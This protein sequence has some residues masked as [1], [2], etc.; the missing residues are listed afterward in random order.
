MPD[1]TSEVEKMIAKVE[2][3][4]ELSRPKAIEYMLE[5]ATG[6]LAALWKYAAVQDAPAKSKMAAKAKKPAKKK[7]P[8]KAEAV[9]A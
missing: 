2:K 1:Y 4:K 5:V 9:S 3:K 7:A 8:A 6:R